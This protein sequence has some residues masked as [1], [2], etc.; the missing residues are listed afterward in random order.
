MATRGF[1]F[2]GA[3]DRSGVTPTIHDLPVDGTGAYAVGDLV[4]LNSSGQCAAVTSSGKEVTG[5]IQE[6]RPALGA[7]DGDIVK[8]AIITRNQI[9]RCSMDASTSSAVV[10]YTK[11]IDV[12]D[13]NTLDADDLSN[14]YAILWK[15]GDNFDSDGNLIAYVIF[16]DTT[17][18][19]V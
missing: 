2:A 15:Y 3:L 10:G 1:E 19:N 14:G 7:A 8:V 13:A 12:A 5:V 11:T 9:W 6:D 16:G 17:F 4:L 18:G